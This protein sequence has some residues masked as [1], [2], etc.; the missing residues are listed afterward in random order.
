MIAESQSIDVASAVQCV[1][2]VLGTTLLVALFVAAR[3][4]IQ[5]AL[6]LVDEHGVVLFDDLYQLL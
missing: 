3:L 4:P 5:R 1:G 6:N 2:P